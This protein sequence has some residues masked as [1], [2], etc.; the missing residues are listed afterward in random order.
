MFSIMVDLKNKKLNEQLKKLKKQ[1]IPSVEEIE[2][3][4]KE[5]EKKEKTFL[6]K[7]FRRKK[8]KK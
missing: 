6:K 4:N 8:N 5:L 7:F 2:K 3:G 1:K